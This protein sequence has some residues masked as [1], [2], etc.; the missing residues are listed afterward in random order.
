MAE[1]VLASTMIAPKTF[2][3]REY[4]LPDIPPNA[5]L[6]RVEATGVCGSDVHQQTRMRG[7][8]HIL[9]HEIV[10]RIARLGSHAARK[11]AFKEGDRVALEEYMPCG[12]CEVCRTE[13][14]RF[15]LQTD[16]SASQ[17]PLFYGT[18]PVDVPPSL[19]GGYSQYLYLHPNCVMHRVPDHIPPAEAAL[20]L[21]MSNGV[22]W[23]YRYGDLQLGDTVLVQ[24]P[25]QQGLSAVLTAKEAG[26]A[27]II[28]TGLSRD[29][30]RL[31][32][33]RQ[34]GAD[35]AI[36]VETEN[37]REKVISWCHIRK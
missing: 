30:H 22:E 31:A 33:A 35:Y 16:P 15:C 8:A 19:W 1:Q 28:V 29:A 36:D 12:A 9:G 20:F 17:Q 23:M 24:G 14:Y 3:V 6:L 10:G 7:T 4:P 5:G 32:L 18:T 13:D 37:F 27:C 34:L 21:P 26:A 25:G 2:E 11:W